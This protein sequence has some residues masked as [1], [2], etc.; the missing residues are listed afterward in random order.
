MVAGLPDPAR[1]FV[2]IAEK[3]VG[4]FQC[5]AVDEACADLG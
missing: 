1:A 4:E 3:P 5:H 2:V